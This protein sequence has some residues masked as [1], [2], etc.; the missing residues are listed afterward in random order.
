MSCTTPATT[1]AGPSGFDSPA[2]ESEPSAPAEEV[3]PAPVVTLPAPEPVSGPVTSRARPR[4]LEGRLGTPLK[5]NWKY[6][7]I[8][9]SGTDTGSEASFDRYH[10]EHKGW[11][12]VG[13]DFVIGNGRGSRDGLV[14]VTFRWEQQTTGAHANSDEYNRYG[15]GICLVGNFDRDRPT[16]RQMDALVALVNYLQRRCDIPTEHIYGHR[17]VRPGGTHCPGHN[18]PWFELMSRLRH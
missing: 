6:V 11:R 5:R 3:T 2:V 14:E 18:F 7:I 13:Y 17:H 15:I 8:H 12:G 10:R 16:A 1:A 4:R 9:H